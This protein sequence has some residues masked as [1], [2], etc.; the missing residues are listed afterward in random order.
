MSLRGWIRYHPKLVRSIVIFIFITGL[1][2]GI[3]FGI[4]SKQATTP[5]K[6][7]TTKWAVMANSD[8]Q[9][10][11]YQDYQTANP[12]CYDKCISDPNCKALS[13][14]NDQRCKLFSSNLYK[15]GQNG[16]TFTYPPPDAIQ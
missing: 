3:I 13:Y 12:L 5:S 6:R 11:P 14:T 10:T 9:M 15:T 16:Y 2:L 4:R 7:D 1:A 8:G